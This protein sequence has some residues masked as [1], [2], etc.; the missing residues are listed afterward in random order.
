MP[1]CFHSASS[2]ERGLDI[3][4]LDA[5]GIA[6]RPD[7]HEVVVHHVKALDAESFGEEF[8]LLRFGMHEHHVG[9]AAPRG[10]ERLAGA[11]RDHLDLD[12]GLGLE[13]RQQI[14]EQ[15][16]I[17]GRG[18]RRHHDRPVLRT[19]RRGLNKGGKQNRRCQR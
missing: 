2:A 9:I 4:A 10:V 12:I 17:L 3:P 1:A 18:G 16:G 6:L 5:G 15:P 19:R 13:D 8:F 11:F 14:A 7:Q